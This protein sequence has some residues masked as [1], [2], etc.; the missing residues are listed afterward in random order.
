MSTAPKSAP[1]NPKTMFALA[2]AVVGIVVLCSGLM[3]MGLVSGY[4]LQR[5]HSYANATNRSPSSSPNPG[6]TVTTQPSSDD[7]PD[8]FK[9]A[10]T[11]L[12][13]LKAGKYDDAYRLTSERLQ[14]EEEQGDFRAR[15][16]KMT[17]LR[18]FTHTSLEK[19][20][21]RTIVPGKITL[22]GYVEGPRGN[23][24]FSIDVIQED[25]GSWKVDG[26]SNDY[27]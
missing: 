7:N 20:R 19:P 3:V 12:N 18:E 13:A 5:G 27:N 17:A 10:R 14:G 26:F 11:F 1:P 9:V 23:A 24:R 21:G 25:D 16:E 8:A 6:V 2:G 15:L 22:R 4:A